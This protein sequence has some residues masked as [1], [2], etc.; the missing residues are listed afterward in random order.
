MKKVITCVG[1]RPNFVK[2]SQLDNVFDKNKINHLLVHTG[3]HYDDMMSNIFFS[4]LKLKSPDVYFNLNEG[5]Q[6]SI[7]SQI[8]LKFEELLLKEKPDLVLVPG[9]VNSSLA[10][11][12]VAN[13]L[14]IPI[15][16]IESG[17]RSFDDTMPEEINRKIIDD[18]TTLFFVT[19]ESGYVNLKTEGK[20]LDHIFFTG[21]TMIDSLIAFEPVINES[22]ILSELGVDKN[23]YILATFHRPHNVDSFEKLS[24]IVD[25]I[26]SLAINKKV[27]FP[28]HPRTFKQLNNFNLLENLS[29]NAIVIDP[30]GY[31]D[32]IALIKNSFMCITDSGG[33]QEETT[34]LGIPCLTIRPNT[35][36][37]ITCTIGTNQLVQLNKNVIL[38]KF[39]EIIDNHFNKGEIPKY[40]DGNSSKRINDAIMSYL[41]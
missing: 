12:I 15:G 19:E 28:V 31:I 4:D 25:V 35:E 11:A 32:F 36:R 5:S 7:I 10:C 14:G 1:T 34:F 18:I 40:W 22:S 8:M 38:N 26:N 23:E 27:V 20:K 39:N 17:L 6:I 21:N 41:Y 3:Q 30:S 13:R 9:D 33:I 24:I 16:H 29:D 37:P 2:V